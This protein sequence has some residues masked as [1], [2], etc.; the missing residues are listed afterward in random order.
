MA[1]IAEFQNDLNQ[2][3]VSRIHG[4]PGDLGGGLYE[5]AIQ[6]IANI[7]IQDIAKLIADGIAFDL[8]KSGTKSFVLRPFLAA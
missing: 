7:S 6:V 8:L 4:R 2:E 1:G 3:Y 5:L